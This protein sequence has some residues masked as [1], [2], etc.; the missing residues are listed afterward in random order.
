VR[1]F[2]G[3]REFIG[4]RIR[5][6]YLDFAEQA[7]LAQHGH[8]GMCQGVMQVARN[9]QALAHDGRVAGFLGEAFHLAGPH[10][11]ATLQLAAQAQQFGALLAQIVEH[12][13]ECRRELR[14]LVAALRHFD[15]RNFVAAHGSRRE[16][17]FL[18]PVG[19][20]PRAQR[21]ERRSR[22][23]KTN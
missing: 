18:Q 1:H 6:M 3:P 8:H 22:R 13:G 19:Q 10:C 7:H 12:F 11:N 23:A 5:I 21:A 9:L 4:E 20:V 15:A 16:R 14:N 2:L 17:Q